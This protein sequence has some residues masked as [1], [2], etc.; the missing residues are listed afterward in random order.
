MCTPLLIENWR[1][2]LEVVSFLAKFMKYATY[3][4][5]LNGLYKSNGL[6]LFS[7]YSQV[8]IEAVGY[9]CY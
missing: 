2:V 3:R 5:Q 1:Y 4:L 9:F 7:F 6:P 8:R